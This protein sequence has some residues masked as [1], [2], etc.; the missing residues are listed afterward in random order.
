MK[1]HLSVAMVAVR[2][3]LAPLVGVLLALAAAEGAM[4]LLSLRIFGGQR[5]ELVLGA[6]GAAFWYRAALLVL[7]LLLRFR[8]QGLENTID[9]LRISEWTATLWWGLCFTAAYVILWAVQVGLLLGGSAYVLSQTPELA[10]SPQAVFL[11]SWR[12][13]FFHALLPLDQWTGYLR[14]IAVCLSAGMSCASWAFWQR[15]DQSGEQRAIDLA[16]WW[17]KLRI[18]GVGWLNLGLALVL[19][20]YKSLGGGSFSMLNQKWG[21]LSESSVADLLVTFGLLLLTLLSVLSVRR[22]VKNHEARL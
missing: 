8:N 4:L 20:D 15:R 5:L 9:H 17:R 13:G 18:D 16:L 2:S 10:A 14:Q 21:P 6:A 11:A 22:E 12:Y 1:K 3:I 7:A 19:L